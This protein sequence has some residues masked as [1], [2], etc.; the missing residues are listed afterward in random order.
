MPIPIIGTIISA[1]SGYLSERNAKKREKNQAVHERE[2]SLIK[3]DTDYNHEA[4]RS[5]GWKDE[6]ITIILS[7]PFVS[8]FVGTVFQIQTLTDGTHEF[9]VAMEK[10]PDWYQWAFLGMI[11]AIFGLKGWTLNKAMGRK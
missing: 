8:F 9:F 7:L 2:L 11:A 6:Y 5:E 10:A 3:S 1:I 4:L